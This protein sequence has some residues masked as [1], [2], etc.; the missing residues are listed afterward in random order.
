MSRR[1]ADRAIS[2]GRVLVDN[3]PPS[4]GQAVGTMDTVTLD[5]KALPHRV[6][7]MTIALH[8]PVGLVCSR[9]GQGS[10]TIYDILPTKY[11]H[12]KAAGRLDKDSSGLLILTN[13]GELAHRLTHP[14]F[15]KEKRY[16]VTLDKKLSSHHQAAITNTGVALDDG[17]SKLDLKPILPG[18]TQWQVRMQEGRNRQIRRTFESLGYRIITLHRTHFG[19]FALED[20]RPGHWQEVD[21]A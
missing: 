7:T 18:F 3:K 11:Q 5:N 12:L 20:L 4:A 16:V 15:Q 10:K 6:A 19:D 8:K 9:D 21:A 1:A 17:V 13:D 14:S 2:E